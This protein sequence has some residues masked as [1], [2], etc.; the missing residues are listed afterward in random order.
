M[1]PRRWP[2]IQTVY[3]LEFPCGAF[4]TFR[5]RL[6]AVSRGDVIAD[7]RTCC[8]HGHD[9][10]RVVKFDR[11][12]VCEERISAKTSGSMALRLVKG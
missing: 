7:E 10:Y 3:V 8:A 11:G 1:A 5:S 9:T 12:Q 4:R 2:G 6:A